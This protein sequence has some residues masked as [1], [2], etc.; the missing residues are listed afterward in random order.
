VHPAELRDALRPLRV[1]PGDITGTDI[2]GIV[3]RANEVDQ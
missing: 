1:H 2:A 3:P